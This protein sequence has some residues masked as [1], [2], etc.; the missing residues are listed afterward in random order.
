MN[1]KL[2]KSNLKDSNFIFKLRNQK[3]VR[4]NSI[5]KEAIS[6]SSHR[7]W[8]SKVLRSKNHKIF[9]ILSNKKKIGY[10]RSNKIG[11]IRNWEISIALLNKFRKKSFGKKS[12]FL[13]EN[14]IKNCNYSAKVLKRNLNSLNL[15]LSCGYFIESEKKKYYSMKKNKIKKVNYESI[16]NQIENIRRKNNKNWMDILRIAFKFSPKETAKTMSLI[17]REDNRISKLSKKLK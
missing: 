14:K 1:I 9:I 12:L 7:I 3:D 13:I 15:F 10:I 8:L 11:R 2:V 6:F 5:N 4:K 16:I 17:Y